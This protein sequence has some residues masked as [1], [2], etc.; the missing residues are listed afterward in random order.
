MAEI[1]IIAA[2]AENNVIGR[3]NDIPWR[4]SEDFRHFK[5]LTMGH[6]CIMG[7]RTFESLPKRP[8]PGRENIILTL[9]KNYRAD[10]AKIFHSFDEALAYVKPKKKAF[11]CGGAT[12]YRLGMKYADTLEITRVHLSPEGDTFFPEIDMKVWKI[13]KEE[14]HE[15]YTF[16]RFKRI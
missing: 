4:I 10:G 13:V 6:P 9:D 16:Q 14:K 12:I 3:N 1:I 11:I 15:G 2:V 7:D 5:E 8:L